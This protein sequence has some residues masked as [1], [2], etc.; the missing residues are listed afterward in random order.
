MFLCCDVKLVYFFDIKNK[1]HLKTIFKLNLLVCSQGRTR[2][3]YRFKRIRQPL[4]DSVAVPH[5][6]HLT[7][8]LSVSI[9]QCPV[10]TLT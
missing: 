5:Y 3:G 2:T 1:F 4:Q 8:L 6:A 7:V 10:P 9:S